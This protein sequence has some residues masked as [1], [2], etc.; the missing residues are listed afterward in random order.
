VNCGVWCVCVNVILWLIECLPVCLMNYLIV[1]LILGTKDTVSGSFITTS[2][3]SLWTLKFWWRGLKLPI[4]LLRLQH[5]FECNVVFG[6]WK[7]NVKL[8]ETLFLLFLEYEQI[9][10]FIIVCTS[11][12]AMQACRHGRV[13]GKTWRHK[14]SSPR[15]TNHCSR[16]EIIRRHGW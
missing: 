7:T 11:A 1:C 14:R 2:T 10:S 5:A 15:A 8:E 16:T 9:V 4:C 12:A 6:L 3:L 13:A